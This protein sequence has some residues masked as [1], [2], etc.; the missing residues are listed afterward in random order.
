MD[1]L[2]EADSP[3]SWRSTPCRHMRATK[4]VSATEP[5]DDMVSTALAILSED[6]TT[7]SDQGGDGNV[8]Q[9]R[10]LIT[11][12][13]GLDTYEFLR[14][15]SIFDFPVHHVRLQFLQAY[16]HYVYPGQPCINFDDVYNLELQL[17]DSPRSPLLMW[18][19]LSAAC[20]FVDI[21]AIRETGHPSRLEAQAAMI[22]RAKLAYQVGTEKDHLVQIQ[23]LLL[24]SLWQGDNDGLLEAP[25]WLAQALSIA[26]STRLDI[27]VG[28]STCPT[29]GLKRRIWW[30]IYIRDVQIALTYHR[31]CQV[32][33]MYGTA[34]SITESDF[35]QIEGNPHSFSLFHPSVVPVRCDG[36]RKWL[37]ALFIQK[38]KLY[39]KTSRALSSLYSVSW[40]L[41]SVGDACSVLYP[42]DGVC[43]KDVLVH[44][45]S[46]EDWIR[47]LPLEMPGFDK[48]ENN[49]ASFILQH[50]ALRIECLFA[51]CMVIQSQPPDEMNQCMPPGIQM[52]SSQIVSLARNL[53]SDGLGRFLP[54]SCMAAIGFTTEVFSLQMS[55]YGTNSGTEAFV[56]Y[57]VCVALLRTLEAIHP[58]PPCYISSLHTPITK[59]MK[60]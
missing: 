46:L 28:K 12:S 44:Q 10:P 7:P 22:S 43:A 3:S 18:S 57:L 8:H 37:A 40:T 19:I 24:M 25:Y 27:A 2:S 56:S 30:C 47:D 42:K 31:P 9:G 53:H 36:S 41:N 45:L 50:T 52:V 39:H 34:L 5:L 32:H 11:Y 49:S 33:E 29:S 15:R 48:N 13:R 54:A 26:K 55:R 35:E 1:G 23:S 38:A 17:P 60:E 4:G 20:P 6:C 21:N 59:A 51:Q 14:Q 58:V 16:L